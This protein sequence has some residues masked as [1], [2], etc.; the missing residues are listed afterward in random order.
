MVISS[1]TLLTNY[2]VSRTQLAP[3]L[4]RRRQ[5]DKIGRAKPNLFNFDI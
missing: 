5:D 4:H 1:F 2:K 3:W